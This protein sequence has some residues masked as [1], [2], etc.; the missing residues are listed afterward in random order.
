VSFGE[1]DYLY[2]IASEKRQTSFGKYMALVTGDRGIKKKIETIFVYRY[3][4]FVFG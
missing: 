3:V 2:P 1:L 4:L